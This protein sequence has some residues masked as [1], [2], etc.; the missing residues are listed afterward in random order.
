MVPSIPSLVIVSN[1][2]RM[3]KAEAVPAKSH[4]REYPGASERDTASSVPEW[5]TTLDLPTTG[6]EERL[7]I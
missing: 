1:R 2:H 3:R 7:G 6:A 5:M 4:W